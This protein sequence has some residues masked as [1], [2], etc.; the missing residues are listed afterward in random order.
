MDIKRQSNSCV[1]P[2]ELICMEYLTE[3]DK[4]VP[5]WHER[6]DDARQML[7]DYCNVWRNAHEQAEQ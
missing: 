2:L 7:V 3:A 6:I 4:H 5:D 1:H